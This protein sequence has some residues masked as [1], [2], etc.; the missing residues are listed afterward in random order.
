M[1]YEMVIKYWMISLFCFKMQPNWMQYLEWQRKTANPS[2]WKANQPSS[3]LLHLHESEML[4]VKFHAGNRFRWKKKK[5][6]KLLVAAA[7]ISTSLTP[8]AGRPLQHLSFNM[9]VP[10]LSLSG[11]WHALN[12]TTLWGKWVPDILVCDSLGTY[13]F[14]EEWVYD[15]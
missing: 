9:P 13:L 14:P 7:I 4:K 1:G 11:Y 6:L 10:S 8:P 3:L 2:I 15:Q 5:Y 12:S